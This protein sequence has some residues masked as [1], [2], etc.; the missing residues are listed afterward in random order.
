MAPQSVFEPDNVYNYAAFSQGLNPLVNMVN[1]SFEHMKD[2]M[3]VGGGGADT[4]G[5]G[6]TATPTSNNQ[7]NVVGSQQAPPP[8]PTITNLVAT[9]DHFHSSSMMM[10]ESTNIS[11][12]LFGGGGGWNTAST[13]M[14]GGGGGGGVSGMH[15]SGINFL[16]STTD[17]DI[18]RPLGGSGGGGGGGGGHMLAPQKPTKARRLKINSSISN[19]SVSAPSFGMA[20]SGGAGGGTSSPLCRNN[21]FS[22][23][24]LEFSA[25]PQILLLTPTETSKSKM[26]TPQVPP[27]YPKMTES[28][29]TPCSR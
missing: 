24:T 6:S 19:V 1:A 5:T 17:S 26:M 4:S 29:L 25:S 15:I 20:S 11:E 22:I 13:P 12:S 16:N 28:P 27:K 10:N 21:L 7:N 8:P 23:R 2:I 18:C 14:G 3:V 9:P